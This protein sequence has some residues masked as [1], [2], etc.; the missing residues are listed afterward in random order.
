V[1]NIKLFPNS[2]GQRLCFLTEAASG[3]T[4]TKI[5]AEMS[6]MRYRHIIRQDNCN[7]RCIMPF[8]WLNLQPFAHLLIFITCLIFF[9]F[10]GVQKYKNI[11]HLRP[12]EQM[13]LYWS[14]EDFVMFLK[15]VTCSQK[16]HLFN[17]KYSKNTNVVKYYNNLLQFLYIL[18]CILNFQHLYSS[19]HILYSSVTWPFRN[20]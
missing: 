18:K 5:P 6:L 17:Q 7:D 19:L 10:H 2:L 20:H 9:L 13:R 16:L 1:L 14:W 4:S 3:D 11:P 15:E 8:Y 12:C